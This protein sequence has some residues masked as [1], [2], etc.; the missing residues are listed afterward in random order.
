MLEVLASLERR[1]LVERHADPGHRRIR[2]AELTPEGERTLRAAVRDIDRLTDKLLVDVPA[3][4]REIVRRGLVSA[5]DR[6]TAGLG[7]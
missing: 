3:D 4:E 2:R 1:G 7:E 5:M 6:L